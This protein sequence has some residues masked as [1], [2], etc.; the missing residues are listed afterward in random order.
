MTSECLITFITVNR[1]EES[2]YPGR[3][4]RSNCF[5]LVEQLA[6]GLNQCNCNCKLIVLQHSQVD[7]ATEC[8]VGSN[9]IQMLNN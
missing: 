2:L 4:G 8:V 6:H 7:W 9:N 5:F 1:V 3:L